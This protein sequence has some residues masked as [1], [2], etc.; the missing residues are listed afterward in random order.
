M[1]ASLSYLLRFFI[2][3]LAGLAKKEWEKLR[4]RY[5][6][7]KRE[8]RE[9]NVSGTGTVSLKNAKRKM[10]ELNFLSWMEPFIKPRE[11]RG[12]YTSIKKR[13]KEEPVF[14]DTLKPGESTGSLEGNDDSNKVSGSDSESVSSAKCTNK[15]VAISVKRKINSNLVKNVMPKQEQ[16][17]LEVLESV[18]QAAKAFTLLENPV[19]DEHDIFSE[20]IAKKMRK[21]AE[22]LSEDEM[23]DLQESLMDVLC[24]TKKTTKKRNT[25]NP[26]VNITNILTSPTSQNEYTQYLQAL[27]QYPPLRGHSYI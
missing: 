4:H 13:E 10:E 20:L 25:N 21:L 6:R 14:E 9:K 11:S 7:V 24:K 3:V 12:T 18:G 16:K 5:L 17:K 8:L 1:G 22:V 27:T 26:P 2:F 19:H 23:E 15:D